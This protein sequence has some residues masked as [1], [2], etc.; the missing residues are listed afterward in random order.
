MPVTSNQP[1]VGHCSEYTI[2]IHEK[3]NVIL[4][5]IC[6]FFKLQVNNF[7]YF[8]LFKTYLHKGDVL[9]DYLIFKV[10]E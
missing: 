8:F 9:N 3:N 2:T 1:S 6:S 10:W 4:S 5:N 7:D